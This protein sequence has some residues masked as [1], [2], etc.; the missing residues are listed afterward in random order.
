MLGLGEETHGDK[1]ATCPSEGPSQQT[2][3]S[4][5]ILMKYVWQEI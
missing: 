5:L 4:L 3:D 1:V 2:E